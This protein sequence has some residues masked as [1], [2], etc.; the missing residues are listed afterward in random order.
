V[1][2]EAGEEVA[3][4]GPKDGDPKGPIGEAD[5]GLLGLGGPPPA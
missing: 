2:H 1:G 5:G 3:G 4:G